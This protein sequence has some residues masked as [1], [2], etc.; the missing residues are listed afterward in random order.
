MAQNQKRKNRIVKPYRG[1]LYNMVVQNFAYVPY[2]DSHGRIVK[3][4]GGETKRIRR[5]EVCDA[6]EIYYNLCLVDEYFKGLY[7]SN[8]KGVPV[9]STIE[10]DFIRSWRYLLRKY[11]SKAPRGIAKLAKKIEP[12]L[13]ELDG[14]INKGL[15][16]INQG[17]DIN[18]VM[19]G[20]KA[21]A[22]SQKYLKTIRYYSEFL[23]QVFAMLGMNVSTEYKSNPKFNIKY[24]SFSVGN[25]MSNLISNS[26]A[27]LARQLEEAQKLTELRSAKLKQSLLKEGNLVQTEPVF[28]NKNGV[29]GV[30][31]LT[32]SY[33]PVI[34]MFPKP[35][36]TPSKPSFK[37]K[38]YD[39]IVNL[40]DLVSSDTIYPNNIEPKDFFIEPKTKII[41]GVLVYEDGEEEKNE[42]IIRELKECRQRSDEFAIPE[43]KTGFGLLSDGKPEAGYYQRGALKGKPIHK[44]KVPKSRTRKYIQASKIFTSLLALRGHHLSTFA[45]KESIAQYKKDI[46][47]FITGVYSSEFTDEKG[48][49]F[50]KFS[51]MEKLAKKVLKKK[52]DTANLRKM[53]PKVST[54]T[55]EVE[56]YP[57]WSAEENKIVYKTKNLKVAKF[58][59]ANASYNPVLHIKALN[60]V[61][62]KIALGEVTPTFKEIKDGDGISGISKALQVTT[63]KDESGGDIEIVVSGR[64]AGLELADIMNM[65]GRFLEEG[66]YTKT[67]SGRVIKNRIE[68]ESGDVSTV[69]AKKDGDKWIYEQR[70]IEPYISYNKTKGQLILGIPGD[71]ANTA[72]KRLMKSLADKISSIEEKKDPKLQ[73]ISSAIASLNPFFTFTAEDFEVIRDTLGS[74]AMSAEASRYMDK[75]YAGLRAK[76]SATTEE[77]L[78][79][80]TPEAIGGFVKSTAKGKFS[81]N[82]KQKEA[83][84]WLEASGMQGVVALD[85]GV[86][87]TLTS[88]VAIKKA[89]NEEMEQ[90]GRK[91]RFL[92]VS[93][94]SL[95]G[96]LKQKVLGFMSEGGD[97]FIRADGTEEVVP[98]WKNIVLSRITEMSYED[99]VKSFEKKMDTDQKVE[100]EA[101]DLTSEVKVLGRS[102]KHQGKSAVITY[103]VCYDHDAKK[104]LWKKEVDFKLGTLDPNAGVRTSSVKKGQEITTTYEQVEYPVLGESDLKT[105]KKERSK[106]RGQIRKVRKQIVASSFPSVNKKFEKEYY[107][108][109]F[110]EINE[111][112]EKGKTGKEKSFAVSSLSHP[113]KVFLTASAIDRDPVDLYRLATLA[114]GQVPTKKSEKAFAEKYGVVLAD[115]MVA[116]KPN[117]EVREQFHN[118]VK[119]N[120][121]FAP[122]T[123]ISYDEMGVEYTSVSLPVLQKLRT[124][125][126]TTR[127]PKIV[128]NK[129]KEEA[130]KIKNNLQAM[131][132]KYR[133]LKSE[134]KFLSESGDLVYTHKGKDKAYQDLTRAT[135]VIATSLKNLSKIS[136]GSF[137]SPVAT[138]IFKEDTEARIL[139]FSTSENLAKK[140]A[141]GN[142]KLR[143]DGVHA[144]CWTNYIVFYQNGS[145]V[146]EVKASDSLGVDAFDSLLDAKEINIWSDIKNRTA[147]LKL[148]EEEEGDESEAT[149]AMDISKK[150]VKQNGSLHTVVCSDNYARGFNFQTFSK[151]V[152]LDR[153][154]G[155][156]SELLKQR[157][158]RA[159]R[160]GQENQV[161]EIYIDATFTEGNK[162]SGSVSADSY[163]QEGNPEDLINICSLSRDELKVGKEYTTWMWEDDLTLPE[164]GE[165]I[166]MDDW[167][168]ESEEQLTTSPIIANLFTDRGY[169]RPLVNLVID[170]DHRTIKRVVLSKGKDPKDANRVPRGLE[171]ISLDQIKSLVNE[172]DQDF[173][174]DI[175]RNGLKSDLTRRLDARISDTGVAVQTPKSMLRAMVD[176]T[177][178]NIST[179]KSEIEEFESNPLNHMFL[180]PNRYDD[181]D[182][183]LYHHVKTGSSTPKGKIKP[184]LDLLGG[185]SILDY[186]VGD[187]EISIS[188]DYVTIANSRFTKGDARIK[189]D[190]Q[191][192]VIDNQIVKL[193]ACAPRGYSSKF[194]FAEIYNAKKMGFKSITCYAAGNSRDNI[195]S[196]YAVWPKFGFDK[197]INVP[198]LLRKVKKGH[199]NY[200]FVQAINNN[201]NINDNMSLLRFL[202]ITA[203]IVT[204]KYDKKEFKAY[205]R[206]IET[207]LER[208]K[209]DLGEI[210]REGTLGPLTVGDKVKANQIALRSRPELEGVIG[211]ITSIEGIMLTIDFNGETLKGAYRDYLT[212][213]ESENSGER[214]AWL[215]AK[216][217][218]LLDNPEPIKPQKETVD[219]KVKIGEKLWGLYGEGDTMS[220]DLTEGSM[221]MRIANDYLKKKASAFNIPVEDFLNSPTDLLNFEDP[222]CWENEIDK[223]QVKGKMVGWGDVVAQYPDAFKSAWYLHYPLRQ[224]IETLCR[225]D[226]KFEQFMKKYELVDPMSEDKTPPPA[227]RA[228]QSQA[229]GL[230]VLG[231]VEYDF[232]NPS[233]RTSSQNDM[234]DQISDMKLYEESQDPCL[235]SVW[236]E[237]RIENYAGRIVAELLETDDD[238]DIIEIQ[239][240]RK[241]GQ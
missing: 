21:A 70:L 162:T 238:P 208:M 233:I 95:V 143:P 136:A 160:G 30:A 97:D 240:A 129:Y 189:V 234:S 63:V 226:K 103:E 10:R 89:I 72:D 154:N 236:E 61:R 167:K 77:N 190:F 227:S 140:V 224:K 1:Q 3:D 127:M 151:V 195:Y 199:P 25:E 96:N 205:K 241:G 235:Q 198:S 175:I 141:K 12:K 193:S 118:W 90:G 106:L 229:R 212:K 194:L 39:L 197:T 100:A 92:F 64:Y 139:Y 110:D 218:W 150:Y 209:S 38:D 155:F 147:S 34:S 83:V 48:T 217:Q 211:T 74:V 174:Q 24:Y 50:K 133:D 66:Y 230:E 87:K 146:S 113:R 164:K 112:F 179:L 165:W 42:R 88:L 19:V 228:F 222:W 142:S 7:E 82:N 104:E 156:D 221:S 67:S 55:I 44:Y 108:C 213:V 200:V 216:Q 111:I 232:K 36:K 20:L 94:S 71:R 188:N 119:E 128:Q 168:F 17:I 219:K 123:D 35:Q 130:K 79:R 191:N 223:V 76:E 187:G 47:P 27:M 41:N 73:K 9:V 114:K 169:V 176:P 203:D 149:W 201:P 116:L 172:A 121:Y 237:L 6:F 56:N 84:A 52:D 161:Q 51:S 181:A 182:E 65:E 46:E 53:Q 126:I 32:V 86:G 134:L 80:F 163:L 60:D 125:T 192:K 37:K 184:I 210:P 22:G 124:Q 173:F 23:K 132:I 204:K 183:W 5:K 131:L 29:K 115:R 33:D 54:Q 117:K 58:S 239:K 69:L 93:P 207:R 145:V 159:Y 158:A 120:A 85:T 231:D 102:I 166:T 49:A 26:S 178:E 99:F 43:Y 16:G 157:T 11:A 186:H 31:Y 220:L 8:L 18:E 101:G 148:A 28:V 45:H 13:K 68:I 214:D 185:P 202:T 171:S 144:V 206:E 170:G 15:V 107:A 75:Y 40:E 152:H 138:N 225:T 196:G 180:D 135:G 105:S 215:L 59:Y 91:R 98:N 57:S 14:N 2:K 109:F 122:K 153:G 4:N 177:P 81:F 62:G 137:K 78:E